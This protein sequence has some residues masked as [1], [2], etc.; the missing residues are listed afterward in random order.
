MAFLRY[1]YCYTRFKYSS[2]V[3]SFNFIHLF[4]FSQLHFSVTVPSNAI[5][6]ELLY[7][8]SF[9]SSVIHHS[10]AFVWFWVLF[11][12]NGS[13]FSFLRPILS[14][15]ATVSGN[16]VL[17][18]S[19]MRRVNPPARIELTPNRNVGSPDQNDN[20]KLSIHISSF[21]TTLTDKVSLFKIIGY[22]IRR[23]ILFLFL[24]KMHVYI[25]PILGR[26]RKLVATP[27]G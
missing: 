22:F 14:A 2:T 11:L 16:S 19:G 10:G 9:N 23:T 7:S 4:D 1:N 17:A 3:V 15:S 12:S 24:R 8:I 26:Y 21:Y 18:V 20:C 27:K 5:P 13:S 25:A 6:T